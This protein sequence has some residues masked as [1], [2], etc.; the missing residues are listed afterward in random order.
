[1]HANYDTVH[2]VV[3]HKELKN[4][5]G[6]LSLVIVEVVSLQSMNTIVLPLMIDVKA[7]SLFSM[8]S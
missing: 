1:M 2:P 5:V 4:D 6:G 3:C 8:Q 7:P